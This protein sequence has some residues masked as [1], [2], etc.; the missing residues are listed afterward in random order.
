MKRFPA[1]QR[2]YP[3]HDLRRG[4][5]LRAFLLSIFSVLLYALLLMLLF[6]I[7]DLLASQGIVQVRGDQAKQ[8]AVLRGTSENPLKVN[9]LVENSGILHS[10][11]WLK[12]RFWVTPLVK[13][14]QN[15]PWLQESAPALALLILMMVFLAYLRS[16]LLSRTRRLCTGSA[17][18][19]VTRLRKTIHRQI[20][21]V[22]PGDMMNVFGQ[23]ALELFR[24]EAETL[25]DGLFWILYCLVRYPVQIFLLLSMALCF[26]WL[27]TL[28]CIIPLFACW[29]LVHRAQQRF[30]HQQRLSGAQSDAELRLLA[31]NLQKT[32]I[33]RGYGMENFEHDRFQSRLEK[34]QQK[35]NDAYRE[36][37]TARWTVRILITLSVILVLFLM[38]MKILHDPQNLSFAAATFLCAI[39]ASIYLPGESLC[40]LKQ[41]IQETE[42]TAD[43]ILSFRD[44]TP[45]VSQAV[46]AKFL[47]PLSRSIFFESVTYSLSN[48]RKL[49]DGLELKLPAGKQYAVISLDPLEARSLA[50]LLPRFTEP[51]AGRILMDSEDISWGTLDSLRAETVYVGGDA[52]FF[53]GTVLENIGCGNAQ[54][55]LQNITDAAK[56]AHAHKFILKL[57]QGYETMLGNHGEELNSGEAYRLG[58]ARAL[59]RDP[60]LMIIEEPTSTMG[61]DTKSLLDDTYDRIFKNRTVLFLPQR[62]STL[63]KVDQIILLYQGKV[64]AMGTYSEMVK[65]SELYRHWEYQNHNAFRDFS[66]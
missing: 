3:L 10:I 11:W 40:S 49:L 25:Q 54:Y 23:R 1:L 56:T 20:L 41:S 33:V 27:V 22:G 53:T 5:P 60:A 47:E 62:L 43:H 44:Q 42:S 34:F 64:K 8:L 58:L 32:R 61:N 18:E 37:R 59:L 12:D 2:V 65:Q 66:D 21:R 57:S 38:G 16:V 55:S 39:F 52:P 17:L 6:L 14:Y 45:E 4:K 35:K 29:F 9:H 31:E 46:G 7:V 28:Q 24:D 51:Q 48:G 13:L 50:Y 26:H 15:A 36:E 30:R 63:K 19:T